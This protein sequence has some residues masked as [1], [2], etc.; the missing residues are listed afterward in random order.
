M[1]WIELILG[2]E[3]NCRCMVC[4]SSSQDGT[5]M[6]SGEILGWLEHGRKQGARGVWFGGGEPTLHPDLVPSIEAARAMEYDN[7]RI[8][9]N[10]IRFA[11]RPFT[12]RCLRAGA[13][14]FAV[15]VKG[16]DPKK[17]DA[18]TR[19]PGAFGHM[20]DGIHHLAALGAIVEADVLV[21]RQSAEDLPAIIRE[22][23]ARGV[24]RFTFWLFSTHGQDAE[25]MRGFLPRLTT[26]KP[27]LEEAF[28]EADRLRVE[29]LT[30]H[31]PPCVLSPAHRNRYVHSGTW[32]LLVV[33]P[34]QEP[35]M[36]EKSPMEGGA[37]L[38]SCSGCRVRPD[39]LGPRADYLSA[40]GPDE[41][42]PL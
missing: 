36:A 15:S 16:V 28:Q 37:Y 38:E 40:F 13:N 30:L 5:R 42:L 20:T 31:T 19:N 8:Q 26:L 35:F 17:H 25:Q 10:G 14:Q 21:T 41:F 24:S 39:C 1:K 23:S 22:F 7:I 27:Y 18:V 6:T 34:G 29:A 11:Y 33:P 12:E 9:S 32:E 4:P 2:F 3:C